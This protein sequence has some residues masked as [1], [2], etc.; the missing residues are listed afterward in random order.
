M[1]TGAILSNGKP[2]WP[3]LFS[4][5]DLMESYYHDEDLGLAHIWFAEVMNDPKNVALSILP[6]P[7]PDCDIELDDLLGHDGAL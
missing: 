1:V 6:R 4:L 2:L 5:E 3:E 7:V